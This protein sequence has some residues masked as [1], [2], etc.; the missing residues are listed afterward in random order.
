MAELG[1]VSE[2]LAKEVADEV[3]RQGI[4]IWL[5]KDAAF[6]D[7]VD[8]L[9]ELSTKGK[10]DYPVV[11]FRRSLL[12][13]VLLLES[14]GS[15]LDKQRLLVHMPGFNEETIRQTP[16]LELYEPGV[17]FRKALDTL[18]REAAHGRVLPEQIDSF[19]TGNPT[20]KDAD[21][22]LAAAVSEDA[23]GL[24]TVLDDIGPTL[25]I[26]G[27]AKTD[28]SLHSRV[29]SPEE[30]QTLKDYLHKFT[31]MGEAWLG[32][33]GKDDKLRPVDNVLGAL[34]A[35]LL[36]VEYVNDLRRPPHL[37][38][39]APLRDLPKPTVKTC[40]DLVAQFRSSHGD[41]YAER[42]NE[43]EGLL[44]EELRVM[45]AE[46]LGQ[47]DTFREEEIRVLDG[48]VEAL[49]KHEWAAAKGYAEA[50]RGERSFWLK[51]DQARRWAWGLVAAAAEF[52]EVLASQKRPLERAHG[53]EEAVER[54]ATDAFKV[55]QAHR[56][57][58]QRRHRLLEPRLPHFGPLQE[59]VGD[60]RRLHRT[61]AD[62]L[63]RDFSKVCKDHGF[64][65]SA[66]L[67]Q[68]SL[69]EDVVH[70]LTT[71]GERVA[72]FAIDAFR[73]EMAAE[74]ADELREGGGF[75]DLK[76][77]LAELPTITSVGMNALA[78]VAQGD[79]LVVPGKFN[80]FTT[81]EFTVRTPADRA[82][83]MGARS[84]GK[85]ALLLD[86]GKVCETSTA[87]LSKKVAEH[88]LVV[89]Q[90]REI[91]DAGE[92]NVGFSTFESTLRQIKAA[93]H[94]L[95]LAGVKQFVFTA[96]HGFLLQDETTD[97]KPFG[98]KTDPSRRHVLDPHAREENGMVPVSL[99]SLGYEG[100]EGYLLLRE[101]TA[102]F[103]TGTAG[104]TFVH[105]G[106]SLQERVI[107]VLTVTRK[108]PSA[109]T[110]T[111]YTVEAEAGSDVMG[112]HRVRVRVNFTKQTTTGLGFAT[113][114]YVDVG[115][116]VPDRSDIRA[117][118][119][120]VSGAGS[121]DRGRVR[122]PIGDTWSEL[123]FALEG[124]MDERAKVEVH[125]PDAVEKVRPA[126][127]DAWFSV[128]GRGGQT[129]PEH[130]DRILLSW[131]DA[132]EHEGY[133]RVFL[134]IEKHGVITE[135]ELTKV[136]GSAR[137]CRKF[138]LEF[139]L[140]KAKLP[141]QV[142]IEPGEGGKRYVREGAK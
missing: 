80:G 20:L 59:V 126:T 56:R 71:T 88:P 73:F 41:A 45:T 132:I 92:A 60:L 7:F 109:I 54:Y 140:H 48:A 26:E 42:A 6:T 1:P 113:T 97:I 58:E 74:L 122:L 107:P 33:F 95:Q 93:W 101:D 89:V 76:P 40:R 87:A 84:S 100:I 46:D 139:D 49:R 115:L 34:G 43:T 131:A 12:E 108:Q 79:R 90:S 75:V 2:A 82:R 85:P 96:D 5:D 124:P 91:D 65:P 103:A 32:H 47:V 134:H 141:F 30:A 116:R 123:F 18:V 112:V 120:D 67:R 29:T 23:L 36:C 27:L 106:N 63:A 53:L 130:E 104:A 129:E 38:V 57:F 98:K 127:L 99:S 69:Y 105:G 114:Q 77:R 81:G 125:H 35:W 86:L 136:L 78:P 44:T 9:A 3:R 118:I 72:L 50:R 102:V 15:G 4:V 66:T 142:R 24:A 13:L 128:S 21:T 11:G 68:R 31:G 62:T 25:L 119:R 39:L 16:M 55:D 8:A 70:P 14:Y 117:I 61:W 110:V 10:F 17:R 28:S 111:E 37:P 52:G 51:R 133:R 22:W 64:L 135:S 138:S 137:A 121:M 19:L 83:A 94:H